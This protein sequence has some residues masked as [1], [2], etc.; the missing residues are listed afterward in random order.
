L[1]GCQRLVPKEEHVVFHQRLTQ[2]GDGGVIE[3]RGEI[4]AVDDRS[5]DP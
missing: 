3:V 4:D 5:E 1:A 2:R